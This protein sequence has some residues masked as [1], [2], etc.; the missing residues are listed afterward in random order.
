MEL[1]EAPSSNFLDNNK[2]LAKL[3]KAWRADAVPKVD[4]SKEIVLVLTCP[5]NSNVT[6]SATLSD[7]GVLEN[8]NRSTL[9]R[10]LGKT[11]VLAIVER[12]GIKAIGK[13]PLPAAK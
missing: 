7:K 13:T 9:R 1:A 10:S 4:F 3:W 2:D 12:S 8:S 6:I 11:Y 5:E